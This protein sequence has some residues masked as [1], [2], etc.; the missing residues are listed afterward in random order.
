MRLLS[1]FALLLL[2]RVGSA[3]GLV[4]QIR[5][6]PYTENFD[7]VDVP[8][9]PT[10]WSASTARLASGDFVTTGSSPHSSPS[11]V[12]ATNSTIS[13][14]LVTP[15]FDFSGRA[16]DKIEYWT[17]RSSTHTSGVLVE[18][19]ID[20]GLTFP[21]VVSDTLKN[22]GNTSYHLIELDLPQSLVDQDHVRFRWRVIG[23]SGG[24]SGTFRIDDV[25]VT[26]KTALDLA[27]S[28]IGVSPVSPV[29]T[30]SLTFSVRVVNRGT[31][32]ASE[33][34]M[35]LFDDANDDSVGQASERFQSLSPPP[36]NSG[37]SLLFEL[38]SS[39][40]SPGDHRVLC[41]VSMAGDENPANNKG[42]VNFF[43]GALP[44]LIVINEI[45][46]A[47]SGGEPEWIEIFNTST[48]SINL[49]NWKI[50]NRISSS[51]YL[52]SSTS[53]SLPSEGLAVITKDSLA[54]RAFHPS[55]PG[56][57]L[58]NNSLP[59]ALFRNDSDAVTLYDS[60]DF[61][62]D[63]LYYRSS[64]V[65]GGGKSLERISPTDLSTEQSNWR[66]SLDPSGSSPGR[67]NTVTQKENDLAA[68]SLNASPAFPTTDSMLILTVKVLNVGLQ[69]ASGYSVDFFEDTNGDS[70]GQLGE[71]FSRVTT[72][73]TLQSGDSVLFFAQAPN[74]TL[75]DH[76]Y[77]VTIEYPLDE[78]TSNNK[79][80]IIVAVGLPPRSVIINEILYAPSGGEPEWV[81][82]FNTSTVA[83]NLRD[84]KLSNRISSARYALTD[85]EAVLSPR[86]FAVVTKDS[87]ALNSFHPSIPGLLL[88]NPSLPTSLFRNDSDA[89]ALY[90]QRGAVM[91][92]LYYRS[93]WGGGGGKSL[94]RIS[95]TGP[96]AERSNW[97]TTLD[98]SGGSPGRVNTLTRKEKD[99]AVRSL[100]AVPVLPM[101]N[102]AVTLT[103]IVE[104][105]GTEPAFDYSVSF[106]EDTN[107][108]SLGQPGELITRLTSTP[109]LQPDD[110]ASFSAQTAKVLLGDHR[111]LALVD[112]GADEEILNNEALL[113]VSAG[114]PVRTVVVN[115][116]M[117]GPSGGE[118]EWIE[119]HNTSADGVNLKNWRFS[120]R[121]TSSKYDL[122]ASDVYLPPKGFAVITRDSLAFFAFHSSMPGLLLVNSDL[123][124]A[125]F[126][127]SGD[128]VVL[129][130]ARTNVM[131]S[132]FY[133]PGWGGGGG[134]SLERIAPEASST[135]QSNWGTSIDPSGSTPGRIN[136]LSKKSH[137]LAIRSLTA[138]PP[139][140]NEGATITLEAMVLNA[141]KNPALDFVVSFY[142]DIN[143]D[144]IGQPS[145]LILRTS[146]AGSLPPEDSIA[147]NAQTLRASAGTHRYLVSA[148]YSADEDTLN[149]KWLLILQ[150]GLPTSS[151][152]I[153]EIVYAPT[154][155]E[156]EWVEL[157]N[158]TN[159]DVDLEN[160]RLSNRT[161][162]TKYTLSTTSVILKPLSYAVVT[163]DASILNFHSTPPGL[164]VLVP[165]LPTAL[166]SNAGDAVVLYDTRGVI[167]DS[168]TYTPAWGGANGKS[169]ER[170]AIDVSSTDSSNWA[171]SVDVEGS[172]PGRQNSVVTLANDLRIVRVRAVEPLSVQD[173]SALSVAL[174][175]TVQNT[176]KEPAVGFSVKF[177]YDADRDSVLLPEE[178]VGTV[179]S[180]ATLQ[181]KDTTLVPF[182]WTGV[183]S[184]L[185]RMIGVVDYNKDERLSNNAAS[186]DLRIGSQP[187][188]LII[189]EIMYAPLTG[190]AEWIELYNPNSFPVD[191]TDWT[192]SDMRDATGKANVFSIAGTRTEIQAGGYAV[193]SSDSTILS[194]FPSLQDLGEGSGVI[195]LNRTS[196]SLNNEGDEVII[197]DLVGTV[198]DSVHYF[199]SWHNPDITDVTGVSLER[200]N[201]NLSS[202]DRRNWSS[203]VERVGGTP[204]LQNSIFTTAIAP[205]T[206]LSV[207]PNPFSP[208]GDG[209]EDFTV[210]SYRLSSQ[211]ARVNVR[212][213]DS[214]GRLV[215]TLANYDPSASTGQI[216]WDGLDDD[217]HRLRM[218]I[219]IVLLEAI[220][221]AG[222]TIESAK[223]AAVVAGRL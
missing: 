32:T 157:Y 31:Q 62:V 29:F 134:R 181:R 16:P 154:G 185:I 43:V 72:T 202:N 175:V 80:G 3:I 146:S 221:S 81:E 182:T 118:P 150:V 170:I 213:F 194:Q 203:C 65:G 144:S 27:V 130:D 13:Q 69:P 215:R 48:M 116:I 149:N 95:P 108:D 58:M 89:V 148:D 212:I 120:N 7:S 45:M 163:K 73:P 66:T 67:V 156:P 97:G 209:F 197:R 115:E 98:P 42:I 63:S 75:G 131:D 15:R 24:S 55:I 195:I 107:N 1:L 206:T 218:G 18:A 151:V 135:G 172:T 201:P 192:L 4:A 12:I 25:V 22:P 26:V 64:W 56:L 102:E 142:E 155:G 168:L 61:V 52:I 82:I 74:S 84:W 51:K 191:M 169:M 17:S 76:R 93:S 96:S 19:S 14:F 214:L 60:R 113:L 184:G 147:F 207:S 125:L 158:T 8:A 173:G 119:L 49:K 30:D 105:V 106:Y 217:K 54:L 167:M 132:L 68:M 88:T 161:I 5:S 189:N 223:A 35:D 117:Y 83:I 109:V 114:L 92:S 199:P 71:L 40:F 85:T 44:D 137:D 33:Y 78:E 11:A 123:P 41:E 101:V 208:D 183:P 177:Y 37:D 23:G 198:I 94:E 90:D 10:G 50:S 129:F 211:I 178:L 127:N 190:Q 70:V 141:G 176:G 166:L 79:R 38:K 140:A 86:G 59:N 34:S 111:Y 103:L 171:T 186:I 180:E 220:D 9:L 165:N 99:L 216:I 57:L 136:T 100:K 39:G 133:A 164:L 87:L 196:L 53:V 112:Y 204:G 47:P 124:I 21:V 160:W 219:Y 174:L 210:I 91:D 187:R 193:L 104:N 139:I 28:S 179:A 46:S 145:E 2:S 122:T 159:A 20:D 153:N 143:G 222:G 6:F 162:A 138:L 128:A 152:V 188:A 77:L 205:R 126:S 200:I 36:I 121:V 110:S